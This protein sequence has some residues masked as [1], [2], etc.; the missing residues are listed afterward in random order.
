MTK[1]TPEEAIGAL[2]SIIPKPQRGDSKSTTHLLITEAL[3]F[4]I[5]T[6]EK[7]KWIP[8]SE[9]QPRE[10]GYY[11]T[12]VDYGEHGFTVGQRY[13]HGKFFGWEDE[14]VIAWRPLSESYKPERD[15]EGTISYD[16]R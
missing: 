3:C 1:M 6:I 15:K 4:A 12:T 2:K 10:M 9:R 16:N 14:C 13:Y 8:C 11:M 7:T 5:D